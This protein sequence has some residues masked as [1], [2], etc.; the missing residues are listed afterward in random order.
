[1]QRQC[2]QRP[3]PLH[4][5]PGRRCLQGTSG[6]PVDAEWRIPDP[7]GNEQQHG[8]IA[9]RPRHRAAKGLACLQAAA[10][11]LAAREEAPLSSVALHFFI[12]PR[13]KFGRHLEQAR[14]I[15]LGE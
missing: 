1:M 9:S 10:L 11:A 15:V 12:S 3:P 5:M 7:I 4:Q 2:G 14:A 13:G 6:H 8:S